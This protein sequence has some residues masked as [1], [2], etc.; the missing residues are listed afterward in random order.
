[1][2]L[3]LTLLILQVFCLV[4]STILILM[5]Q[6]GAGISSVFGGGND[7]YLTRRGIEKV[8]VNATVVFISLFVVLRMISLFVV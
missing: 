5:Q 3:K 4:A 7:V 6:R 8:V 2:T 1:M